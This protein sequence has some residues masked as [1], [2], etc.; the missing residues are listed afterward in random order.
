MGPTLRGIRLDRSSPLR[1]QIYAVLRKAIVTGR[2]RPGETIDEKA[3]ALQLGVSR[4]PVREAVKK[5]TD[6]HL[7]VVAA[8]SSTRASQIDPHDVEQAFVIRRALELESAGLA[9]RRVNRADIDA[10]SDILASHAQAMRRKNFDDAIAIDDRFHARIA[11]ISG[12]PR[13]WQAIEIS[14]AQLDRCRHL[15][16]PR[17]GE[18]AATLTQHRAII[19][20]LASKD[21]T[22]AQRAMA[23]HLE[24]NYAN[25]RRMLESGQLDRIFARHN[26]R[27]G[28]NGAR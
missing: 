20:A 22:K 16:V 12:M 15:M 4:T 26:R 13:L 24:K 8:Q 1:D 3:I 27:A 9:S 21:P 7:V 19:R 28:H 25:T 14:K 2:V 5:L 18:A 10:L 11:E 23:E 6:E 17:A